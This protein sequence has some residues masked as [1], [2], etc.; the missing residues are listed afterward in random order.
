VDVDVDAECGMCGQQYT[1]NKNN[2]NQCG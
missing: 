1:H 2:N